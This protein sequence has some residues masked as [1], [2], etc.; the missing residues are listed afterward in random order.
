M[1][2]TQKIEKMGLKPKFYS[3]DQFTV[4]LLVDGEG[5]AVAR[6][7]SICSELDFF[8][9]TQGKNRALGRAIKALDSKVDDHINLARFEGHSSLR[10]Y[11][12][13]YAVNA[14]YGSKGAYLPRLLPVEERI[15]S[16]R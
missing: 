16:K 2:N 13:L 14:I 12:R 15:I 8:D 1:K 9:S 11:L 6:G 4:C 10:T 5:R 3:G 7:I